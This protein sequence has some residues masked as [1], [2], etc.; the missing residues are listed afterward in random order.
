M[1]L[2]KTESGLISRFQFEYGVLSD[3][4]VD[5][6]IDDYTRLLGKPLR[7][8]TV[9]SGEFDIRE[10]GWSDSAT[11]FVL[12]YK[13]DGNHTEASAKLLDNALAGVAAGIDRKVAP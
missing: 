7:D 1:S 5:A 10:L 13:T 3:D 11:T 6:Q 4:A 8:S 12:S 2:N 9:R